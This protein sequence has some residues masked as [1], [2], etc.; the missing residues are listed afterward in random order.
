MMNIHQVSITYVHEQD[1]L[2][3]RIN[4]LD[5][6]ETKLWLTRRLCLAM[7]P[8]LKGHAGDQLARSIAPAAGENAPAA[9]LETHRQRLLESFQKEAAAYAGDF[10]TPYQ[11]PAAARPAEDPPLLVTEAVITLHRSGQL[12]LKF[13]QKLEGTTRDAELSM[14]PQLSQGLLH[15]LHQGLQLSGWLVVPP[16]EAV[17]PVEDPL[18]AALATAGKPGY[19]N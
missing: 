15:L 6:H 4:T 10:K 7:L 12:T 5:G 17:A 8:A 13:A 18:S 9:P 3:M 14:P 16:Q 11:M 2:L 19:L 1:R